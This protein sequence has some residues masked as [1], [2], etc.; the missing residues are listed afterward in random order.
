M[1]MVDRHINRRSL[2]AWIAAL[3]AAAAPGRASGAPPAPDSLPTLREAPR[4]R[5]YA[6]PGLYEVDYVGQPR[7][8]I[9][10]PA[11]TPG[12]GVRISFSAQ[13]RTRGEFYEQP[14]EHFEAFVIG[15]LV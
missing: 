11:A 12:R 6:G 7:I 3:P 9:V 4:G 15:R 13:G 1:E 10:E 5:R 2:V 14:L 8:V